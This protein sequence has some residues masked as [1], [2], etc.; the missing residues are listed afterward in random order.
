MK[1]CILSDEAVQFIKSNLEEEMIRSLD[2]SSDV[3]Q[4]PMRV[5]FV[6][7]QHKRAGILLFMI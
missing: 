6:T 4:L 2:G 3:P 5:T 1:E 7:D